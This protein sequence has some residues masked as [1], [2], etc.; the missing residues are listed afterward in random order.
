MGSRKSDNHKPLFKGYIIQV[1]EQRFPV[2]TVDLNGNIMRH[3]DIIWKWPQYTLTEIV[4]IMQQIQVQQQM[5]SVQQI[6]ESDNKPLL[7]L[8]HQTEAILIS[9]LNQMINKGEI[10]QIKDRFRMPYSD[11]RNTISACSQIIQTHE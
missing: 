5:Q 11:N 6:A 9:E 4:S 7:N 10:I 8:N 2:Q 3:M 1:L